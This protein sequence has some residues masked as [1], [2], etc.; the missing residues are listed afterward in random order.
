MK[1]TKKLA[2][3]SDLHL[4]VN[5]LDSRYIEI[6]IQTLLDEGVTDLHLAGDISNDFETLSKPFL[7]L[8]TEHFTVSYNLGNHDMLGMTESEISD[9][10]FQLRALGDKKLLS[11]AGWYDYS[12]C[13]EIS[14]EQNLRTKNTFWFDRKIKRKF[15]DPTTTYQ[16]LAKLDD[17]LA[18]LDTENLIVAMHF[19]PDKSFLMTHSKFVKFNAFMGS[20][21]FH[22]IFMKYGIKNVVFGHNHRSYDKIIDGV[23]YQSKPLGYK[24]EWHLV[25]DY[26]KAHPE[27]DAPNTHNLHR[28]Y[29]Q[30]KQIKTFDTY[31]LEHFSEEIKRSVI[32]F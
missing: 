27:Y 14:L 4:D 3:M 8:L 6:L 1:L 11:F 24:R 5:H 26:F 12:F 25:G 15:D 32:F 30:L 13:P 31:L 17:T 23:H 19:V 18:T 29:R 10:D 7:A 9:K 22:D 20:E 2:I 21:K 28:R 16:I